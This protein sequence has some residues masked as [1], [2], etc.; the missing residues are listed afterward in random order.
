MNSFKLIG[1]HF[2]RNSFLSKGTLFFCFG[3]LGYIIY[4][5]FVCRQ[6]NS[7]PLDYLLQTLYISMFVFI[8]FMFTSYE[9][10]Y[11]IWDVGFSETI[12][13]TKNGYKKYYGHSIL[14]LT[15][16]VTLYTLILIVINVAIYF[17][18]DIKH[19]EYLLHILNNIILNV[20]AVAFVGILLGAVLSF[21]KMRVIAYIL[22]ILITFLSTPAF[23]LLGESVYLYGGINIYG[24]HNLFN[25]F[26]P[27]L[28]WAPIQMFGYSLLSYRINL[29]LFWIFLC[30]TIIFIFVLRKHTRKLAAGLCIIFSLLSLVGYLQPSSKL[31]MNWSNPK[32]GINTDSSYYKNQ[33][34]VT[35][36]D[37]AFYVMKYILDIDIGRQL[38]VNATIYLSDTHL[39][40]YTFTLYHGYKLKKVRN[41]L[42][43]ELVFK[44]TG[45]CFTVY[46]GDNELEYLTAE[47][48]GS[49][50]KFYS[51]KQGTSLP[52]WF[53]YYPQPGVKQV[54]NQEQ[55]S[56]VRILCPKKTI[57]DV[58]I[59]GARQVFCNLPQTGTN[60]FF[61]ETD[62]LTLVSGLYDTVTYKGVNVAY[63]YLATSEFSVGAIQGYIDEYISL[64][65][66]NNEQKWVLIIP[67]TNLNS[68]YER[69]CGFSDHITI[70]Q[71]LGLPIIFDA[72]KVPI[73][74][75]SLFYAYDYYCKNPTNFYEVVEMKKSVADETGDSSPD[76]YILLSEMIEKLGKDYAIEQVERFLQDESDMIDDISFLYR[77]LEREKIYAENK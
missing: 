62:G 25:I 5:I 67:N 21:I 76:A 44:Q 6:I 41:Q 74:K 12:K 24:I 73:H 14:F 33:D 35:H 18:L 70:R 58:R 66:I 15:G 45:D 40:S 64:G 8:F 65:I 1:K 17:V 49:A 52:G 59:N 57:F 75:L 7:E 63:P 54:Y 16:I 20:F 2:Y 9:F 55:S 34:K 31:T 56:F 77:Q 19:T 30:L 10:L 61:G 71:F 60:T 29:I 48:G 38:S 39:E 26:P 13:A 3:S 28:K 43:E 22:I 51:N 37:A 69:F 23:D 36:A 11:Q 47:Y 68:I 32:E 27:L 72:Q 53:A 4:S 50:V 42:G 46:K